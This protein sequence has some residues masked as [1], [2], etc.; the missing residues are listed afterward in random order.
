MRRRGHVLRML[1]NGLIA[2]ILVSCGGSAVSSST[3]SAQS[4][5]TPATTA[6]IVT[7]SST[8][9]PSQETI[10]P[11]WTTYVSSRFV[12]S[13]DYPVDWVVTPATED[14]PAAGFP[15][16]GGKRADRFGPISTSTIFV[17]VSSVPF[18]AGRDEITLRN[19][20]DLENPMVCEMS[21]L[22]EIT[23]DGVTGRQEDAFCFDRD[24]I[25]EVVVVN[26]NRFYM[27]DMF[28]G[29]P[30]SGTDRAIFDEFLA[31]FRF[32][33]ADNA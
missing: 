7:S 21:E 31:S 6:P 17:F 26:E 5:A 1:T 16:P 24:H 18:D 28:S 32:G 27:I 11:E 19:E 8:S 20:L 30:L 22:H 10:P 12:Y 2:F 3:S 9:V 13:I 23:V 29:S 14:W 4:T 25:I 33:V 15:S